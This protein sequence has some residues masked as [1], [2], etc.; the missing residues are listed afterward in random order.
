MVTAALITLAAL[1]K[2]ALP[3]RNFVVGFLHACGLS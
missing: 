1:N 3:G 2:D